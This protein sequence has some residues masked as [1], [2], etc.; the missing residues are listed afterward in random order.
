MLATVIIIIAIIAPYGPVINMSTWVNGRNRSTDNSHSSQSLRRFSSVQ[1][2]HKVAAQRG[3]QEETTADAT[4][5][6]AA[7]FAL[8]SE[9]IVC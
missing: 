4:D 2:E 9:P 5:A 3:D 6:T 8:C 7:M 1:Q